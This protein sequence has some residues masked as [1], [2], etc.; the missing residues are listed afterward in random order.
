MGAGIGMSTEAA[1]V[2]DCGITI[3]FQL[4]GVSQKMA[5]ALTRRSILKI[6]KNRPI[7]EISIS[8]PCLQVMA[9]GAEMSTEADTLP[10][11]S[12]T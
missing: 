10:V 8:R 3:V 1:T 6:A 7:M 9:T 5:G 4:S 12:T 11:C 2:P